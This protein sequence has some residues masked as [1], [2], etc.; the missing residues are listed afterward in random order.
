MS[1][2]KKDILK[3][4]T[5]WESYLEK[6]FQS[7]GGN[8]TKDEDVYKNFEFNIQE[9]ITEIINSDKYIIKSSLGSGR[10]A[11]TPYIGIINKSISNSVKEGIF[12]CYLFSRNCKCVYLS[13]GIGAT[14][15][16]EQFK[17]KKKCA[18][19]ISSAKNRFENTFLH[20]S[21]N[22]TL[23]Q[24]NLNNEEDIR[25]TEK[26]GKLG[27]K[28][29]NRNLNY[30]S[31]CFFT[32]KYLLDD[33]FLN[34]DLIGDL[35]KYKSIYE[36]II[37]DP[38]GIPLIE[39][40]VDTVFEKEDSEKATD[41]NYEI[42]EFIPNFKRT[43]IKTSNK[44]K[45][46]NNSNNNRENY[47]LPSK[48]VG[49]AGEEHVYNFEFNYL[50]KIGRSDLASKIVKQ[51]EDLTNFP[52]Y[53]IQSFDDQGN[54]VYIEVKS[55]KSE[56]RDSFEIS[57]NEIKSARKYKNKYFI[58][59]VVN[60]LKDPKILRKIKDPISYVDRNEIDL[61]PWIYQMKI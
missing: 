47:S 21:P 6:C 12:L 7:N 59:Q 40:L 15:F 27:S 48:K 53:D 49:N 29:I 54:K 24:I 58:Y 57:R 52:G 41:Y 17:N 45:G 19:R 1:K 51:Y 10:V 8:Q 38:V 13:L 43:E 44:E 35:N 55:T 34:V 4:S 14:Q 9:Q 11:A 3:F 25:F 20:L 32:K 36:S 42:K 16:E 31:G 28:S 56:K 2:L 5:N 33:S 18:E 23:E 50:S 39:N 37:N 46:K 30:I 26:F 22:K 60:A 61:D